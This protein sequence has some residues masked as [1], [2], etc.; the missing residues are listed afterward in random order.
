MTKIRYECLDAPNFA[1]GLR[2]D[3]QAATQCVLQSDDN[4]ETQT[5]LTDCRLFP[6]PVF[7]DW[8]RV[9]C[10]VQRVMPSTNPMDFVM[11]DTMLKSTVLED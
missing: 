10:K 7:R 9:Y 3:G 6:A 1:I 8:Y 4:W 2:V 5:I 11:D